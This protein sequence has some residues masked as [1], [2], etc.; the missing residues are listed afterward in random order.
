V[1]KLNNEAAIK[2]K[3]TTAGNR[4]EMLCDLADLRVEVYA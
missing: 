2:E 4:G 3:K 1:P